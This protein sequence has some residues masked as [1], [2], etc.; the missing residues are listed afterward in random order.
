MNAEILLSKGT[1]HKKIFETVLINP[2]GYMVSGTYY[3]L[4]IYKR[5]N[6]V[7]G[8]SV[9]SE[10]DPVENDALEAFEILVLYT[11]YANNYFSIGEKRGQLSTDYFFKP[12]SV[13]ND[14]LINNENNILAKGKNILLE[15]GNLQEDLKKRVIDF[16][17]DYDHRILKENIITDQDYENLIEILIHVDRVQYFQSKTLLENFEGLKR[18]LDEMKETNIF[19]KLPKENRDFL[20]EFLK[21]KKEVEQSLKEFD[22]DR[23]ADILTDNHDMNEIKKTYYKN[24]IEKLQR[25][26]QDLRYPK[27]GE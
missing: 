1:K 10:D 7:K 14:Y 9:I 2:F 6:K 4:S 13:I 5:K 8:Y 24:G 18:M 12:V 11:A 16:S 23:Q 19:G 27:Q 20:E 25:Y 15:Y 21:G 26:K 22:Q 3:Y 17:N